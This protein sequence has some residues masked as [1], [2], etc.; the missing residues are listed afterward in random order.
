MRKTPILGSIP[1]LKWA[2]N[3][4]DKTTSEVELMVFLRPRVIQSAKDATEA[5]RDMGEQ[6]PLIKKWEEETG[7]DNTG[8][9]PKQQQ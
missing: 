4:K 3:K 8:V 7:S 6:A 1:L 2:F 9:P 5:L